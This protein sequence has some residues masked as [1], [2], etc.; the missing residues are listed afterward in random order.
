MDSAMSTLPVAS[1][2]LPAVAPGA[3]CC[4]APAAAAVEAG[5]AGMVKGSSRRVCTC[6]HRSGLLVPLICRRVG[7]SPG[8]AA[9]E[10]AAVAVPAE[11]ASA[12]VDSVTDGE[13]LFWRDAAPEATTMAGPHEPVSALVESVA[14][15]A[16]KESPAWGSLK[17]S[18]SSPGR[19]RL[20]TD[21]MSSPEEVDFC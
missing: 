14:D 1:A 16:I 2:V 3:P 5:A 18:A 12:K 17:G 8:E 9:S 4:A 15:G 10:T 21:R 19:S 6:R 11:P 7:L 13:G 20:P